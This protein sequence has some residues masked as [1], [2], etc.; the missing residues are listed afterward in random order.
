[1]NNL[2][3][4]K[5]GEPLGS[6]SSKEIATRQKVTQQLGVLLGDT[7]LTYVR[8]L[9]YHW[10][11]EG[12]MFYGIHQLLET[13]YR[14]LAESLDDLAERIRTLGSESPGEVS[15]FKGL[16]SIEESDRRNLHSGGMIRRLVD[17]HEQVIRSAKQAIE[18][19]EEVK[20]Y[21][22]ADLVTTKLAFHEKAVW[23]LRSMVSSATVPVN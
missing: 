14:E 3:T 9:N 23:M 15:K 5:T 13:Q 11:V 17:D 7:F 4:V 10:N 12:P 8:T 2:S 20:D 21:G 16:S 6:L 19:A 1:M 22:T 18:L